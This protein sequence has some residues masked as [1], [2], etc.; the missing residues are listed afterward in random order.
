METRLQNYLDDIN[1]LEDA[2]REFAEA[3]GEEALK[4]E[5]R[6]VEAADEERRRKE[7]EHEKE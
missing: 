7:R 6:A 1:T 5:R 3:S 4:Q 2:E